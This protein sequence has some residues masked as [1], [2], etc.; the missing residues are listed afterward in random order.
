MNYNATNKLGITAR[1]GWLGYNFRNPAMF[2]ALG[3]LPINNTAAKAGTGLGDTYTFT[4]SAFVRA[5]RRTS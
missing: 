1:L 4:G 3:G 2:G 5:C